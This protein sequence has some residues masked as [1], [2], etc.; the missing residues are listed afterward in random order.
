MI[1]V[2]AQRPESVTSGR[3]MGEVRA[4][5]VLEEKYHLI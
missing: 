5:K 3:E 1:M 2:E 4:G